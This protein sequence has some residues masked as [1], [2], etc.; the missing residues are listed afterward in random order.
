M[1]RS[2]VQLEDRFQ[3]AREMCPLDESIVINNNSSSPIYRLKGNFHFILIQKF[4]L[5]VKPRYFKARCK[6]FAIISNFHNSNKNRSLIF[7]FNLY[8]QK[9]TVNEFTMGNHC[10]AFSVYF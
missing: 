5:E 2:I 7:F 10:F 4:P 9:T 3:T 6:G 8:F 1:S